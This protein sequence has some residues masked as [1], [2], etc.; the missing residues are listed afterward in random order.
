MI[1]YFLL[2]CGCI[3][4]AEKIND[5]EYHYAIILPRCKQSSREKSDYISEQTPEGYNAKLL[6]K[7]EASLEIMQGY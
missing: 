5:K 7:F 6:T 2:T 1:E 4:T 3:M